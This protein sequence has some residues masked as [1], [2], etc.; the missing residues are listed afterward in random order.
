MLRRNQEIIDEHRQL[1]RHLGE[2]DLAAF[3]EVLRAHLIETRPPARAVT[4]WPTTA[5]PR[6]SP[7]ARELCHARHSE[8]LREL[9]E[10]LGHQPRLA[11][12]VRLAIVAVL[13][14]KVQ[15]RRLVPCSSF[16]MPPKDVS[17]AEVVA[18]LRIPVFDG[19]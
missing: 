10:K 16:V 18:P 7:A 5:R 6:R 9:A 3:T 19:V 12:R 17:K 4:G 8:P 11:I 2:D 14:G 13:L 15:L 1:L